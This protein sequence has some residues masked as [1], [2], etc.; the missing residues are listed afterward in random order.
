MGDKNAVK[1]FHSTTKETIEGL[2][3]KVG[4]KF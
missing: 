3:E 1:E 2:R 4:K